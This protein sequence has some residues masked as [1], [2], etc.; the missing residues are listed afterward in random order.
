MRCR[1]YPGAWSLPAA[2]AYQ[3][4]PAGSQALAWAAFAKHGS[5][6][7]NFGVGTQACS[8]WTTSVA[9]AALARAGRHPCVARILMVFG[10]EPCSTMDPCT[11]SPRSRLFSPG[12]RPMTRRGSALL[13]NLGTALSMRGRETPRRRPR[14]GAR[15]VQAGAGCSA[16]RR[17]AGPGAR[18]PLAG[19][20]PPAQAPRRWRGSRRRDRGDRMGAGA[21]PRGLYG[22][23]RSQHRALPG[24][25]R[26]L[27]GTRPARRPGKRG[28][29]R[30]GRR[31]SPRLRAAV[32][33][34]VVSNL[35]IVL[36]ARY[37]WLGE[38]A[39]LNE[40]VDRAAAA[41]ATPGLPDADRAD[42]LSG[43]CVSLRSATAASGTPI[44]PRIF[45]TP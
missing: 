38:P 24:A 40:S 18:Q 25:P 35:A 39:D 37:E 29:C 19:A 13:A 3:D 17:R 21:L 34:A 33:C 9:A 2:H 41:A 22:V 12:W 7:G 43:L 45:G 14:P 6:I 28:G 26:P 8:A 30:P 10:T 4:E 5:I 32:A 44:A 11:T 1:G 27:R 31:G 16:R 23:G 15:G 36:Q 42:F 20:A